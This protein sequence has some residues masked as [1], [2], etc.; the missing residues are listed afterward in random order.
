MYKVDFEFEKEA[1]VAE[2]INEEVEKV[3]E[4]LSRNRDKRKIYGPDLFEDG[5]RESQ[6]RQGSLANVSGLF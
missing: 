6:V 3:V 5:F 2:R 1:V 4:K